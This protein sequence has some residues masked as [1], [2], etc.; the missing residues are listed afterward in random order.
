MSG[1]IRI[2]DESITDSVDL[3]AK[4]QR[5]QINAVIKSER[6][7]LAAITSDE[8]AW[9]VYLPTED[10][11]PEDWAPYLARASEVVDRDV[12]EG[13]AARLIEGMR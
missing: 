2:S 7:K 11:D 4:L 12:L 8:L 13:A 10:D 1:E 5:H 6:A 3:I 9:M